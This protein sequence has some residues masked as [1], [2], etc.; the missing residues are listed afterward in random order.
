MNDRSALALLDSSAVI[1][2]AAFPDGGMAF[3]H[4]AVSARLAETL[5]AVGL[6]APALR[7]I[8]LLR[9]KPG[10]RFVVAYDV[11]C[12][13]RMLGVIGKCRARHVPIQALRRLRAF[14][15]AGFDEGCDDRISVPRPIG[16]WPDL[17]IWLQL[18]APGVAA[19]N[20]LDQAGATRLAAPVA[21]AA[22]K[23][24]RA[25]VRSDHKHELAD[26]LRILREK[27]SEAARTLSRLASRIARLASGCERLAASLPSPQACGIHRDFYSDQVI[28]SGERLCVID[29]D[30]YCEGDPGLD[31]GNFLGHVIEQSL[32]EYGR[33]E[34]LADVVETT[35]ERYAVLAGA[36]NLQAA[37]VY[38]ELTLARHVYLSTVL[39]DRRHTT[40]PLLDLCE[41]R[42]RGRLGGVRTARAEFRS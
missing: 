39:P 1:A 4:A 22:H 10:R 36:R 23:I 24:H 38:T 16:V 18:E 32:R 27:L 3:S 14:W 5:P 26:E 20:L 2:D 12:D 15:K 30:L 42:I 11:E 19:T 34:A 37:D 13:G 28:V 41:S 25:G 21:E 31:I 6:A 33:T 17:G 40:E 29:F 8:R 9:H 7:G 35:R